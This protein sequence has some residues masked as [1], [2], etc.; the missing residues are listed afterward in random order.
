MLVYGDPHF[1]A[2]LHDLTAQLQG[3]LTALLTSG[4]TL[5]SVRTL[6]ILSGQLEQAV[7]DMPPGVFDADL[8]AAFHSITACAAD[9]FYALWSSG[10]PGAPDVPLSVQDALR[11][12]TVRLTS[13]T[14]PQSPTATVKLPEGF[15]FYTLYPEQYATAALHWLAD[16]AA[17]RS[18]HVVVVGIRSIG[19]TLGA[20]V[21][22]VLEA[23]GWSVQSLTV[24]PTGHPFHRMASLPDLHVTPD[25][26][27]LI[28][29]EGPGISGS[30]MASA[31]E[32][33]RNA[34]VARKSISF[35]PGH[36]GEPG[37]AASDEVRDWWA[38][39]PRYVVALGDVLFTGGRSLS[40]LLADA[41][42]T[43]PCVG[44]KVIRIED[45]SSG[46]WRRL[47]Y[48]NEGQWP[49]LCTAFERT[50]Y[51]C[52][53]QSGLRILWKFYGLAGDGLNSTTETAAKRLQALEAKG[54]GADVLGTAH[55]FVVTRWIEGAPL[56]T[57]DTTSDVLTH[58][59]R[60]IARVAGAPLSITEYAKSI[61]RLG[62]MLYWNT[63]EA[64]GEA[65]AARVRSV[66]DSAHIAK[67][68]RACGDGHLMPHEW[69]RR[70]NG[71]IV[72]V[73]N[74]GH[75]ADHTL[76]GK[77]SVLWDVAGAFVEWQL[78]AAASAHL[79]AAYQAAGGE[80]FE[81]EL[82]HFYQ[83]A[84]TA[85]RVGQCH[86]AAAQNTSEQPRLLTAYQGYREQLAA[87]IGIEA[88]TEP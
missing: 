73:D 9:A 55:G 64:L 79:I 34:G 66:S 77:Q 1:Q 19:T 58:I 62:E 51:R 13:L 17:H 7:Q 11:R 37:Q 36:G 39:T 16:H 41:V 29:D 38:A 87:L 84:Y 44:D 40:Q 63:W 22:A 43:L 61:E 76:T 8:S 15:S 6:L 71:Q 23:G 5:D 20:V 80:P 53:T 85:F 60:Y 68:S 25:T 32:A 72:K 2:D 81:P 31:A 75:D 65:A 83:L 46:E 45:L 21:S 49:A 59:G 28:V 88:T 26:L 35:F 69:L 10:Q 24:R 18:R 30:S 56:S 48:A 33:L 74:V 82:L 54:L 4:A 86:L 57:A 27:A 70:A 50:K 12:M 42:G 14:V 3:R 52:T 47:L 67:P 78:D